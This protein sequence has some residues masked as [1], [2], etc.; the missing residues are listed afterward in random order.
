MQ[1]ADRR[2][3]GARTPARR[4]WIACLILPLLVGCGG[5]PSSRGAHVG[6]RAPEFTLPA[7]DGSDVSLSD[8]KG[9]VVVINLWATWC[10]P[11][12]AE[13]PVLEAAY[14]A[15]K[16]EGLVVLGISVGESKEVVQSF[17][18]EMGMTYPVLLDPRSTMLDRLRALGLPVSVFVDRDGV[19][20]ARHS[21]E[22]SESKLEEYL[23]SLL[24]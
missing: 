1:K 10:P 5:A 13:I 19:V 17:V 15:H 21:G 14:R 2:T 12:R 18:A 8:Y 4:A 16:A 22:L 7:L 24:P 6:D 9:S 3:P 20:R 23:D 11:C